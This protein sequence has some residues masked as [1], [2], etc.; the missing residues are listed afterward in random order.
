MKN[1]LRINFIFHFKT[2][3]MLLLLL[4]ALF[5]L[6]L[7]YN[8]FVWFQNR[9]LYHPTSSSYWITNQAKNVF[10]PITAQERIHVQHFALFPNRPVIMFCHGNVGN[11]SHRKYMYLL[12]TTFQINLI[13]FDYRG[14]GQ[15]YGYM[16]K[17]HLCQDTICVYQY[18]TSLYNPNQ[19]I[20]WGESL[21]GYP[22]I[23]LAS[24]VMCQSL[25]VTSTFSNICDAISNNQL[26]KILPYLMDTL[27][28]HRLIAKVKSK[29]VIIHSQTD[30]LIPYQS[31]LKLFSAIPHNQKLLIPIQGQHANPSFTPHDFTELFEFIQIQIPK[32]TNENVQEISTEINHVVA[33]EF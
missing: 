1:F 9:L 2:H 3:T 12:A 13:L 18:L 21:G 30:N 33:S 16:S 24:K 31:A 28:N 29:I 8:L 4:I 6:T 15:S 20:I 32:P 14:Y 22:A 26:K 11:I 17:S 23:Y 19:I 10:L 7:I 5:L 25:I 27:D